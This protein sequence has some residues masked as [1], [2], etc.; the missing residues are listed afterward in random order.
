MKNDPW[1]EYRD[2]P[3]DKWREYERMRGEKRIEFLVPVKVITSFIK[4]LF[5]GKK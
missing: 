5:G 1:R 4:K 2:N 3:N